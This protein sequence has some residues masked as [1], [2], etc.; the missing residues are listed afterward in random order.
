M[1]AEQQSRSRRERPLEVFNVNAVRRSNL[2][3]L[4]AAACEH[5]GQAKSAADL[6]ELTASYDNLAAL[7]KRVEHQEDRSGA[8]VDDE[9]ILR[10]GNCTQRLADG[11]VARAALSGF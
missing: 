9:R 7:R 1:H 4:G 10:P 2:D 8:V 6:H 5:F 3:Q 11:R